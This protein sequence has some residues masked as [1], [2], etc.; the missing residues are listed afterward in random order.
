MRLISSYCDG[1]F[2]IFFPPP[3]GERRSLTSLAHRRPAR[4]RGRGTVATR[5]CGPLPAP[6][7]RRHGVALA[8]KIRPDRHGLHPG[9][10]L[11]ASPGSTTGLLR[12]P[13]PVSARCAAGHAGLRGVR[14]GAD[15]QRASGLL[16]EAAWEAAANASLALLKVSGARGSVADPANAGEPAD[17]GRHGSLKPVF[18]S[19]KQAPLPYFA[20]VFRRIHLRK[21]N[22]AVT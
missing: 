18:S 20:P 21:H 6:H 3:Y 14:R 1:A 5:D 9:R 17:L 12:E 10:S 15:S 4:L 2:P 7:R 19:V 16:E 11:H 8:G 22:G 13:D